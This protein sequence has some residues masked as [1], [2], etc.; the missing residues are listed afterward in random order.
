MARARSH[1]TFSESLGVAAGTGEEE[2]QEDKVGHKSERAEQ[3]M[4]IQEI[5]HS[6]QG[7]TV[8]ASLDA[9]GAYHAV[10]IEPGSAQHLS[11]PSAQSNT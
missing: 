6:L 9:C 11:A 3:Y 7:A 4:N 5:L 2:R 8:F 10:R 1:R